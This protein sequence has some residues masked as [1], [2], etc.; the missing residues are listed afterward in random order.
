MK[1][2]I[3]IAILL[4]AGSLLPAEVDDKGVTL[5]PALGAGFETSMVVEGKIIDG[6]DAL[7]RPDLGRPLR[8]IEISAIGDKALRRGVVRALAGP[9]HLYR[10]R[11]GGDGSQARQDRSTNLETTRLIQN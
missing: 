5:Q 2:L 6:K 1:A 7:L 10:N 3:S 11:D 8:L 9:V 4:S